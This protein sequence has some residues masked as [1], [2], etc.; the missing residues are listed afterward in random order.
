MHSQNEPPPRDE[1][2]SDEEGRLSALRNSIWSRIT[3]IGDFLHQTI[4]SF[5]DDNAVRMAAAL[6][7]Y[8][9]FSIVPALLMALNVAG[10]VIGNSRAETE[11][12]ARFKY[13][14]NPESA[15][16]V[17][18]LLNSLSSQLQ[19]K[20]LS[21][22][23]ILG[24][25]VTATGVF[26]ELQ[27]SLNEIWGLAH[28]RRSGFMSVLRSRMVSFVCVVGIGVLILVAVVS[29]AVFSLVSS[30][31]ENRHWIPS[32]IMASSHAITQFG[33][34]PALLI[35]AYK[36][37]PDRDIAWTDVLLGSIVAS[38]LFLVGKRVFAMYI[39]SSVLRSIYGAAGSLFLLL[40]WVYY[41]AYVFYFGA[42]LTKVYA[43][44]YGSRAKEN[45]DSGG[46]L[47]GAPR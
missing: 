34:I 35:L 29:N 46:A 36:L 16:Y 7:F 31:F 17:L 40:V 19:E 23:A 28:T 41:S 45:P 37:I 4:Q 1:T 43:M 8:T 14:V 26:V 5:L 22:I 47:S 24:A 2:E 33:M 42:E 27:S 25:V 38:F 32:W 18:S 9:M 20:N 6:A 15:E 30:F 10:F 3:E 39:S 13:V 11:L 12:M 21:I 44:R